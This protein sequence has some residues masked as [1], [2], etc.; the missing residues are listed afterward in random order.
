VRRLSGP[1][2]L[3]YLVT[4]VVGAAV[5]LASALGLPASATAAPTSCATPPAAYTGTDSTVAAV[6]QLDI[7]VD[8]NCKAQTDRLDALQASLDSLKT[9]NHS[10]LGSIEATVA[11]WTASNPLQ[12]ALPAGG[13]G[14][15]VQVTNWPGD[16]TVGLDT[17]SSGQLDGL[18]QASHTDLWILIGAI[19]GTF[20]FGEALRKLWP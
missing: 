4:L 19:V 17:T 2:A 6:T 1:V 11:G 3:R 10:D 8:T 5:P 13:S 7:D 16:Q 14:Q 12:V 20:V 18:G 9:A 15:A